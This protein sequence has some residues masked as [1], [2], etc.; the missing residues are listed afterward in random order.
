MRTRLFLVAG[1][2]PWAYRNWTALH[3]FVP[4]NT[5]EGEFLGRHTMAFVPE[6]LKDAGWQKRYEDWRALPDE[7]D[8]AREGYA[9]STDNLQRMLKGGP[10]HTLRCLVRAVRTNFSGDQDLLAWSTLRSHE[11]TENPGL[12]SAISKRVRFYLSVSTGA[13]YLAILAGAL[14]GVIALRPADFLE[15]SGLAFLA[16]FFLSAFAALA[17]VEGQHRYHFGL[18]PFLVILSAHGYG[19]LAGRWLKK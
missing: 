9:I 3:R 11:G 4:V 17:S 16:F 15:S 18:M 19:T 1:L 10:A 13:F 2:F 8:R 6:E 5:M 12:R 7:V 14:V